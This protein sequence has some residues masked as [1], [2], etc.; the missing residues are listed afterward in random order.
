MNHGLLPTTYQISVQT[1]SSRASLPTSDSQKQLL[2][3]FRKESSAYKEHRSSLKK[4]IEAVVID[5]TTAILE[6]H[7]IANR[8]V[9]SFVAVEP[10]EH[11]QLT[12]QVDLSNLDLLLKMHEE[13]LKQQI[14]AKRSLEDERELNRRLLKEIQKREYEKEVL[15]KIVEQQQIENK[16]KEKEITT[17]SHRAVALQKKIVKE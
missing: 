14:E 5:E 11:S 7:S 1:G 16:V 4:Q 6:Q 13:T 15:Q 12:G 17:I 3:Q 8:S 9:A 2:P 10:N